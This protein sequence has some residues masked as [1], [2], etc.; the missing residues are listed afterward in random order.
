[1]MC[2]FKPQKPKKLIKYNCPQALKLISKN[3][4]CNFENQLCVHTCVVSHVFKFQLS[5][6]YFKC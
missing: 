1:M 3:V 2:G 6:T 5:A 4:K